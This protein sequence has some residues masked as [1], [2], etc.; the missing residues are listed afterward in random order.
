[1]K[2]LVMIMVMSLIA[3]LGMTVR[4][5]APVFAMNHDMGQMIHQS[6]VGGYKFMYHL[7]DKAARD[8]MMNGMEGM[9]MPGM[10]NSPDITSHLMVSITDAAGK[11]VSSAKVGYFITGPDGK[12][13]KTLTMGMQDGYGADVSFKAKG[14]YKIKTKVVIGDKTLMDDF[15]YDVK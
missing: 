13:Q 4:M 8:K 1:M 14:V 6:A 2:K 5:T 9:E 3:G 11:P 12:E 10:S 15:T 7:L